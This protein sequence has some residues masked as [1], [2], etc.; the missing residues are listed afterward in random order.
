M[1]ECGCGIYMKGNFQ[2]SVLS[3]HHILKQALSCSGTVLSHI[4][5]HPRM[6]GST[7]DMLVGPRDHVTRHKQEL[8]LAELFHFVRALY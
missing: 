5:A 7:S 8:L 1:G 3:F 2:M 4:Q 6:L